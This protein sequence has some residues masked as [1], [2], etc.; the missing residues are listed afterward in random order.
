MELSSLR[1]PRPIAPDLSTGDKRVYI[2]LRDLEKIK[3]SKRK[4]QLKRCQNLIF[5]IA[6]ALRKAEH[7]H[8]L[9][10]TAIWALINVFRIYPQ[11]TK[12]TM[13]EAGVPGILYNVIKSSSIS[14]TSR[15]YASELCFYL[16]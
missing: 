14:G 13:L 3:L 12:P 4:K 11:D 7:D 6:N 1:A 9:H 16:R 2:I 10:A 5:Y 15:Q 8:L